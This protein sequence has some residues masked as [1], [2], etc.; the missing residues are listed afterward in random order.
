MRTAFRASINHSNRSETYR[1]SPVIQS[2]RPSNPCVDPI[3]QQTRTNAMPQPRSTQKPTADDRRMQGSATTPASSQ[4]IPGPDDSHH[5]ATL[6]PWF[7]DTRS[8][9]TPTRLDLRSPRCGARWGIQSLRRWRSTAINR[10][11]HRRVINSSEARV[12]GRDRVGI[13]DVVIE[14]VGG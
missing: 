13:I 1:I 4:D 5:A 10:P 3:S 6:R 12:Q 7:M 9:C 8:G 14:N 2:A 11:A